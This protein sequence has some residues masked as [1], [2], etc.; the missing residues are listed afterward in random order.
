L[1]KFNPTEP[2]TIILSSPSLTDLQLTG[3]IHFEAGQLSGRAF[4]IASAGDSDITIGGSVRDLDV[5]L[6]G[7]ANLHAKALSTR[8]A[9]VTLTGSPSADITVSQTLTA[10]LTGAGML[11]YS[12]NPKTVHQLINGAGAIQR[13]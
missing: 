6:T 3:E 7:A 12:G 5:T 13:Q 2:I 10:T 4:R 8:S 9:K 1:D 11:T